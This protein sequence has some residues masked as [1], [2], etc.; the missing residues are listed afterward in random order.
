MHIEKHKPVA[1]GVDKLMYVGDVPTP[2]PAVSPIV[3]AG[4][5]LMASWL[6][7]RGR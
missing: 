7:L 1:R 2:A 5:V 6:L 3:I 4:L